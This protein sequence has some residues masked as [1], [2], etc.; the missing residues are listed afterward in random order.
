M[1]IKNGVL[2]VLRSTQWWQ[3]W[4]VDNDEHGPRRV[5]WP[6][7]AVKLGD[8]RVSVAK[9]FGHFAGDHLPLE[10][11]INCIPRQMQT[12]ARE[13]LGVCN[14][15]THGTFSIVSPRF[16]CFAIFPGECL[17][18]KGPLFYCVGPTV[19]FQ[20]GLRWAENNIQMPSAQH[21]E[22]SPVIMQQRPS[23]PIKTGFRES[24]GRGLL[25]QA[26]A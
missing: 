25:D 15:R 1:A 14:A 5:T 13:A 22:Q 16:S 11:A 6:H 4:A 7:H 18:K 10:I 12:R 24:P 9:G 17:H 2:L 8:I 26:Q 21:A 23:F 3:C 19:P 20:P